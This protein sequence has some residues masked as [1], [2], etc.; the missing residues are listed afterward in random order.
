MLL[1][2]ENGVEFVCKMVLPVVIAKAK[3]KSDYGQLQK[4]S[5]IIKRILQLFLDVIHKL[6]QVNT[7]AQADTQQ[8]PRSKI[9]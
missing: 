8:Q 7:H 1:D 6:C 9:N 5:S 3:K 2:R 4:I